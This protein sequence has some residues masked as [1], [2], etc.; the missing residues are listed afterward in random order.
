MFGIPPVNIIT[1]SG[2]ES[3]EKYTLPANSTAL[4]LDESAPRIWFKATDSTGFTSKLIAYKI[5]EEPLEEIEE[6]IVSLKDYNELK[7]RLR[8][9]ER[10]WEDDESDSK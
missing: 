5:E 2:K 9:L 1:V 3:A 4:L 6:V 8:K 10:M 7:E